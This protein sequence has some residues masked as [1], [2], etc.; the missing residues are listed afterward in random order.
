MT[1]RVCSFWFIMKLAAVILLAAILPAHA[2]PIWECKSGGGWSMKSDG[3]M[4]EIPAS[5]DTVILEFQS[6]NKMR[7]VKASSAFEKKIYDEMTWEQVG[8]KFYGQAL[9][10]DGSNIFTVSEV[11][12]ETGSV[13]TMIFRDGD[14][15]TAIGRNVCKK[16][17]SAAA[18]LS[19]GN[20]TAATS[21]NQQKKDKSFWCKA[22]ELL[23]VGVDAISERDLVTGA[24]SINVRDQ[25]EAARLGSRSL[26]AILQNAR[27]ENIRIFGP[28]DASFERVRAISKRLIAASHYRDSPNVRYE[29]VDYE[30]VNAFA[31]GGGNYL[32]LQGLLN[33]TN[34]AEL[35]FIIGHEIAHS[36]AGHIE[37]SESLVSAKDL[38]GDKPQKNYATSLTN[39]HEQEADKIAVL[40]TAVAGY[41]PCASANFWE[42]QKESVYSYAQVRT[43]PA[44]PRRAAAIRQWCSVAKQYWMPGQ[45]NP[46]AEKILKCNALF[47]NVSR[48]ELKACEGGGVLG[49]LEVLADSYVKNQETKKEQKRQ[50]KQVSEARKVIAQQQREMP[51]EVNW[52]QGWNIYKGTVVRHGVKAGLNFAIANGQGQFFYNHNGQAQQGV[53]EFAGQ[54]Q[55]GYWFSWRDSFGAGQLVLQE[56]T[57]GSLRGQMF[58]NDG[59]NPGKLLG[60]W[61]GLR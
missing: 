37:E 49:V 25:E 35:A 51:P 41:D 60:D 8:D 18:K 7:P 13:M 38:V 42:R 12:S 5:E 23:K 47:C 3:S 6:P 17:V 36:S 1:K 56:Y 58:I 19:S 55:S 43:H 45:V 50:E 27:K 29:V 46:N 30:N 44:N 10:R 28:G 40:Y 21:V 22:D 54:N 9:I 34:D 16:T 53:L 48:E 15:R 20:Q 26:D 33:A 57:D 14:V 11:L 24:R 52:G 61:I 2:S 32:V 31:Y 39:V 4:T 59:T